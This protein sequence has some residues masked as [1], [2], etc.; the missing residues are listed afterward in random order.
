MPVANDL[1]ASAGP[2]SEKDMTFVNLS[3]T[4][5]LIPVAIVAVVV[6]ILLLKLAGTNK[7]GKQ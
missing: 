7:G 4:M 1:R 3:T 2:H 6:V 5:V